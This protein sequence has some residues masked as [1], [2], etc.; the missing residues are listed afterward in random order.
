MHRIAIVGRELVVEV[1]IA[2]AEGEQRTKYTISRGLVVVVRRGSE[3]VR[4]AVDGERALHVGV[5]GR[6]QRRDVGGRT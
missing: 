5:S 1:V 2:F 3:P 6:A 4:E